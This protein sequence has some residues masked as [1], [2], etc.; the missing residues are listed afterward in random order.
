MS[1][2]NCCRATR[3]IF[4]KKH[5]RCL[6]LV[7]SGLN[8]IKYKDPKDAKDGEAIVLPLGVRLKPER[9]GASLLEK[10]DGYVFASIKAIDDPRTRAAFRLG[11]LEYS[12]KR[13][14]EEMKSRKEPSTP[15]KAVS[16]E[17]GGGPA[18]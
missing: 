17:V 8:Q 11:Y 4:R 1:I 5:R 7:V 2:S 18:K 10:D 16:H 15:S 6:G 9:A 3:T 13:Y 14:Q 12:L